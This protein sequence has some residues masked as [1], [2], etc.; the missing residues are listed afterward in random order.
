VGL[1]F[2]VS[3]ASFK[4]VL[5]VTIPP[6]CGQITKKKGSPSFLKDEDVTIVEAGKLMETPSTGPTKD[7]QLKPFQA[8][9][10]EYSHHVFSATTRTC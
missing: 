1:T 6:A 8:S 7:E 9:L 2:I 5:E 4:E 3:L 10:G